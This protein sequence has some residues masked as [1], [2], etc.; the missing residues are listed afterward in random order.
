[1]EKGTAHLSGGAETDPNAQ[2]QNAANAF[3]AFDDPSIAQPRDESGRFASEEQPEEAEDEL[4]GS[5]ETEEEGE[6]EALEEEDEQEAA[7]E[8]QPMPPSWPADKADEWASL[9]VS[10]QEYLV[11]REA[12]QTRAV[13]AKF[14]EA[15]N[16][17]KAVEA[18]FAEAQTSR[19]QYAEALEMLMTAMQPVEP[20]PREYGAG[21]GQYDRESYD[22]AVAQFR[23]QQGV[24]TQLAE[25]WN[26]Q[27]EQQAQEDGE[28]FRQWKAQ[29]EEQWAPKFV[30]EVPA[31]SDP[32][33]AQGILSKIIEYGVNNG[34]ERY[35]TQDNHEQITS[36]VLR[37]LWK[38][39][40]YDRIKEAPKVQ[41]K[42]PK[43][44]GPLV[45][46]GVSSTRSAQKNVA[47]Q[48]ANDRLAREGTIEAG[49]AVWKQ[50]L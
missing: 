30:E 9:P 1:M 33:Q 39:Q 49:A 50:F 44:A 6:D 15:A 11:E 17:R 23:A 22:L 3:K 47:R 8:A 28:R 16:A 7:E 37:V 43:A 29:H 14:Q 24:F 32:V 48:K 38:A 13:N 4:E 12:E 36:D 35:F 45:K 25:Q 46:P 20:D 40:E 2:L 27:R 21:T 18:Q 26:A 41:P 19:T 10:T 34:L 31:L 5:D 42:K